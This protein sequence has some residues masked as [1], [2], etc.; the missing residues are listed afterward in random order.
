MVDKNVLIQQLQNRLVKEY[1]DHIKEDFDLYDFEAKVDDT[2][3]LDENFT[4]INEDFKIIYAKKIEETNKREMME[5]AEQVMR[6]ENHLN[7]GL[8]KQ[9]ANYL[10]IGKKGSGKSSLAWYTMQMIHLVQK[11][12]CYVYRFPR[13][14]LLK[15]LPFKVKN[16]PQ[17]DD[18][19]EITDGV[20]LVDEAHRYFDVL[21]KRTNE[22]L[23][24]LLSVSRQNNT[25][26]IF[27]CHNSYFITRNLFSFIDVRMI[28]E[29]N[30]GHWDLERPHMKRIYLN[31]RV[32]GKNKVFIDSDYTNGVEEIKNPEWYTEELSTAY[33]YRK[34]SNRDF[35]EELLKKYGIKKCE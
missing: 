4:E 2:L 28:K 17:L 5:E 31:T 3:C 14:E 22:D 34:N 21:N 6:E 9:Q 26:F 35:Y 27:C 10:V 15:K 16:V 8:Y 19:S 24:F 7:E 33:R 23:K 13:P 11:K 18:L 29:V 20:V 32:Y 30:K 12:K 25:D 1:G